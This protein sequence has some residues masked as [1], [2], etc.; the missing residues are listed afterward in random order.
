MANNSPPQHT[1]GPWHFFQHSRLITTQQPEKTVIAEVTLLSQSE[2]KA[3]GHLIAAAP[4]L[5]R[6]LQEARQSYAEIA[7]AIADAFD[8]PAP[9]TPIDSLV[10]DMDKV[11][12]KAEGRAI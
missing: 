11:I 6:A 3:N 12:A 1:P 4:E 9:T 7:Q 5:L 2:R 10:A 8:A